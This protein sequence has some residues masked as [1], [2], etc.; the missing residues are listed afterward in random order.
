M[1]GLSAAPVV[2]LGCGHFFHFACLRQKIDGKV[3][4]LVF[5]AEV[6]VEQVLSVAWAS[7]HFWIHG[8]SAV[9]SS[10]EQ[11]DAHKLDEIARRAVREDS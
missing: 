4:L 11:S 7:H 6:G 5:K 2:M 9:Q 10:H 8:L 3:W 1:D